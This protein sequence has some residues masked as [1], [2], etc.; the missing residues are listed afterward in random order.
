MAAI[1]IPADDQ[2]S[3]TDSEGKELLSASLLDLQITLDECQWGIAND[4]SRFRVW[5]PPYAAAL[6][7][8]A[9]G[10]PVSESQAYRIAE[11]VVERSNALKKSLV[12]RLS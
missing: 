3:F 8:L 10:K 11:V 9:G 7:K 1:Q 2:L 6:S 4:P 12:S 5:I